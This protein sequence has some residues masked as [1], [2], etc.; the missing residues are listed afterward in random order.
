MSPIKEPTFFALEGKPRGFF[1]GPGDQ[2]DLLRTVHHMH[3]YLDLFKEASQFGARG[4]ASVGYLNMSDIA[5]PKIYHLIPEVK[6]IAI[7]RHPADRA[8]SKYQQ[9]VSQ[10]RENLTFQ[11]A[12]SAEKSRIEMNWGWAWRYKAN[13]YYFRLLRPFYNHFCKEQI[14]IYLYDDWKNTPKIVLQDTLDYLGVNTSYI[15]QIE[16]ANVTKLW[17]SRQLHKLLT[18]QSSL[19]TWLKPLIPASIREKIMKNLVQINSK[20]PPP[21]DPEIRYYL[22]QEYRDDI[23]SLQDLIGRDLSHW[24][25]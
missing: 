12:L 20:K 2:I 25:V 8:Y 24:L 14:R 17:R 21:L 19:K 3:D 23:L 5:A 18:G 10:G 22:I 9:L 13:G 11:Q 4:E 6:L 7:L 16:Y 15:P 1:K